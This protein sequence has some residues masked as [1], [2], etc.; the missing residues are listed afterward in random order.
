MMSPQ[1]K[2]VHAYTEGALPDLL[3]G[4]WP[5]YEP[6]A[7]M[8]PSNVPTNWRK[9]L[10]GLNAAIDELPGIP[11]G[12]DGALSSMTASPE[13]VYCALET[14]LF[15]LRARERLSPKFVLDTQKLL[16]LLGKSA[17]ALEAEARNTHPAWMGPT[18]DNLWNHI[19]RT[20]AIIGKEFGFSVL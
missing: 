7:Y 1:E 19:E 8:A 18:N 12:I 14:V 4:K 17:R 11:Q 16:P 13:E 5:Y 6:E 3:M 9:V 20:V 10:A 2:A 15:Y